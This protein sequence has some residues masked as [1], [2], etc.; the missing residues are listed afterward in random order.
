M[1]IAIIG[2]A[3]QLGSDLCIRLPTAIGLTHQQIEITDAQRIESVLIPG[4]IELVINTGLHTISLIRRKTNHRPPMKSMLW[5]PEIWRS[6]AASIKPDCCMSA[7]IMFLDI[8]QNPHRCVK[9][10][11]HNRAVPTAIVSSLANTSFSQNVHSISLYAPVGL[12]GLAATRAKGNFVNTMLRL[13]KSRDEL[14]VVNDQF[15]TPTSTVDLAEGIARLIETGKFGTYHITNGGAVSWFEFAAQI[16]KQANFDT[17]LIPISSQE[18]GAKAQ[19]P[20]YSVL[21]SEK[22]TKVTGL[23]M[24]IWQDALQRYLSAAK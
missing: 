8:L 10:I 9:L 22:F 6:G 16:F 14:K 2:S 20:A 23:E 19:R 15:C 11:C 18:F 21:N 3:G 12:Y 5:E 7:P 13:G 17:K 1:K 4:E 24:P